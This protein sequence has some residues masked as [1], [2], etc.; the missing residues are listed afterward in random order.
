MWLVHQAK[1]NARII[2][3]LRCELR[4]ETVELVVSGST[5]GLGYDVA[6]PPRVVVD[7]YDAELGAG[8]QAA[9]HEGIVVAEV[10]GVEGAA[11]DAIDE[12]L[13]GDWEAEGVEA[14]L[15]HEV[16]HLLEGG[17]VGYDVQC[18]V[19]VAGAGDVAAEVEAGHVDAAI[20]DVAG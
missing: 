15:L 11:E 7:V 19:E 8:V 14:V 18:G 10:C 1:R 17:A 9:L 6:V 16:V 3:I 13:P 12:V 2:A 20:F 5:G 4:P